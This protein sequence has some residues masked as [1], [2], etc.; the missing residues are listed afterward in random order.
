MY[1]FVAMKSVF[2]KLSILA[3][4][5]FL[6]KTNDTFAR[7]QDSIKE[8]HVNTSH[9]GLESTAHIIPNY[10][11]LFLDFQ[12]SLLQ[13]KLASKNGNILFFETEGK[14]SVGKRL[15]SK[16]ASNGEH[17]FSYFCILPTNNEK[18][19]LSHVLLDLNYAQNYIQS[20]YSHL[21]L[22]FESMLI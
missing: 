11:L 21:Y 13:P 14:E 3:A 16:V 19:F 5:V 9:Q 1:S 20:N 22:V 10:S 12:G 4:F 6:S 15:K 17:H 8:N 2:L 18:H 7:T